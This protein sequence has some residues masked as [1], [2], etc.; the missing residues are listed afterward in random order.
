MEL[1]LAALDDLLPGGEIV[2]LLYREPTPLYGI[3]R[4]N[5]YAHRTEVQAD[6]TFA[7][8]IYHAGSG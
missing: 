3:L 5:G 7:I 6:G 1:T 8:H 4:G 2:L